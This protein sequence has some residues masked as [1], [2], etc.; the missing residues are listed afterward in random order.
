MV[1]VI[2]AV[3]SGMK[4]VLVGLAAGMLVAMSAGSGSQ[5]Q[6]FKLGAA[7][8]S[9]YEDSQAVE[10]PQPVIP[11]ALHEHCFKSCCI[12][13]FL[14]KEDGKTTVRLVSSSGDDEVDQITLATLQRWKFRPAALNGKP[15]QST[16]RI[17]VE[18]EVE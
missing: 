10:C 1:F 3:G 18:F 12:A 15:V 11:A 2:S 17:K 7:E 13:R 6:T 4:R 8:S 16:R 5:A 9:K 14:I